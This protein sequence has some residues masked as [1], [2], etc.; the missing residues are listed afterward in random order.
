MQPVTIL[1]KGSSKDF[2]KSLSI[3]CKENDMTYIQYL[4]KS[5]PI[6]RKHYEKD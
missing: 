3:Y 4:E 1:V 6:M 5:L 2:R